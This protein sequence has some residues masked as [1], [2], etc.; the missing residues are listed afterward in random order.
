M[1]PAY[2]TPYSP[3]THTHSPAA[4]ASDPFTLSDL[5]QARDT[6]S[7]SPIYHPTSMATIATATLN[8][9]ITTTMLTPLPLL[10]P[11]PP[12]TTHIR[13]KKSKSNLLIVGNVVGPILALILVFCVVY[14]ARGIGNWKTYVSKQRRVAEGRGRTRA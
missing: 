1:P 9:L 14:Y 3:S 10:N 4:P 7:P 12:Q 8:S 2:T 5:L 11:N 6:F 13:D